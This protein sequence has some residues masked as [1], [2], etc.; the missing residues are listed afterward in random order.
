MFHL[1][2]HEITT[3]LSDDITK[4][5]LSNYISFFNLNSDT[6][7]FGV[8]CWNEELSS[9]IMQLIGVVEIIQRN[10][11]HRHLSL[12]FSDDKNNPQESTDWYN[13]IKLNGKSKS[14]IQSVTHIKHPK[15]GVLTK[16]RNQPTPNKVISSMSYGFW[17]HIID[18]DEDNNNNPIPWGTLIPKIYPNH[19]QRLPQFWDKK[20]NR[21]T[22]ISRIEVVRDIRNRVAHFEPIWKH[23][24][25]YE[26]KKARTGINPK[27]IGNE[28]TT[29]IEAIKR[30]EL[31]YDRI[32]QLLY[33][34]S[35]ER[36]DAYLQSENHKIIKWLLNEHVIDL[37][38][39]A[40]ARKSISL[41]KL[42][43]P[44]RIKGQ[45]RAGTG[46][47]VT[48]KQQEIGRFQPFN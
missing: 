23:R 32:T 6:E 43:K 46:V 30:T 42:S 1:Q 45:L 10:R 13:K 5:R 8:Y 44:W 2:T 29:P 27:I 26:E 18:I 33:W 35:K 41:S 20:T 47:I 17:S 9:R 25:L 37:Y 28:P 16:K 36:A 34:M 38:K 48:D 40:S 3:H 7:V 11:I 31:Y 12:E 21:D 4:A 15:T 14:K 22:L 39:K 24:K 19:Q